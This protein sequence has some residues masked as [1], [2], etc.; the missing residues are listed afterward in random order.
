[1]ISIQQALGSL[2][3]GFLCKAVE[4]FNKKTIAPYLNKKQAN[5]TTR[6]FPY[7]VAQIKK[8]LG[9]KD[10]GSTYLFATTLVDDKLAILVCK[11]GF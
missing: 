5:I 10:G 11:K 4:N 1:M 9:V 3:A 7:S 2:Q 6:N 8:K